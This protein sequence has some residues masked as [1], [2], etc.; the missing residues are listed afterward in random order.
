MEITIIFGWNSV[1]F[2]NI[3]FGV[4]FILI[5][6]IKVKLNSLIKEY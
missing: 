3:L 2:E 6:I 1:R 4:I 5:D